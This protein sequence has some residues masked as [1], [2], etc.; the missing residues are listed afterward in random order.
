MAG[1][2][3]DGLEIDAALGQPRDQRAP[4]AVRGSPPRTPI[5]INR[6]SYDA[7]VKCLYAP[8]R[9]RPALAA[10]KAEWLFNLGISL[11][12]ARVPLQVPVVTSEAILRFRTASR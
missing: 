11:N 4:P 2:L 3:R 5:R 12:C 6:S 10:R 7:P 9:R 1:D 8:L